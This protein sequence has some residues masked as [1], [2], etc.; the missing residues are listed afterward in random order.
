MNIQTTLLPKE[1]LKPLY[2]DPLKLQFGRT[3][4]D[5]MFTMSFNRKLGWHNP[6]I[7]PYQP[8]ALDPA[9]NVFHYSQEVFEGQ[10]A[11]KSPDGRILL[12]RPEENAKRL[13]NSMRR[14]CMPEIPVEDIIQAVCELVKLEE[15]WIPAAE[16][17]SLY[18]RPTVIG[19][20]AAL[21]VKAS[22]EYL[23]Y[24]ILSPV[25]PYFPEGFNPVG[26]WVS[27]SFTRAALGGTG[28]AKTGGNYAASLLASQQAKDRGYSQVLW[29]DA[30]EHRYIE[31]VGAM[32]IFFV[33]ENVLVTPPL[34]GSILS[35]ITRRSVLRLAE[36]LGLRT[37][38]RLITIDEAVDGIRFQK[39]TEVF[40]AGTA[41]VIS[42]V[43]KINY[44]GQEYVVGKKA[45]PW[46]KKFFE[47]LTGIQTGR[48]PDKHGWVYPVK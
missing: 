16:G 18:I 41:A 8:L 13:N 5:Y 36:D 17:C 38:Q 32:N 30:K 4:T 47:T 46:A 40:A 27:D 39:V 9:A 2:S 45:G 42:P 23:F 29:L 43:G 20:E 24:I 25:G 15:R 6:E 37:E 44:K 31:E 1:K 11:Y 14:I 12:F 33:V 3:F 35:G 34:S 7:K 10:K 21:G 26:L 22:D 28:E 48:L 19:T